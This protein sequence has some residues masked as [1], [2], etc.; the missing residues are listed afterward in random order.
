MNHIAFCLRRVNAASES[1]EVQDYFALDIYVDDRNLLEHVRECEEPFASAEGHPDLA[2]KYE[3]LPADSILPD[4]SGD[5]EEKMSFYDCEC[6]CFG[7]WPLRARI[8]KF[9]NVITW[10]EFEQSHRGPESKAS[11]WRYDK[12]GPFE[13]NVDQYVAALAEA[14]TKLQ[15]GGESGKDHHR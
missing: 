15:T 3:A 8:S 4:L 10:S 2:G 6:G 11:W 13:F 12:L 7:C 9:Q 14:N 5:Q 1:P